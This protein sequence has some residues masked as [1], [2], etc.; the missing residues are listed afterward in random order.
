[1]EYF[2]L[3]VSAVSVGVLLYNSKYAQSPV[4]KA[5]EKTEAIDHPA[6]NTQ[7]F[8]TTKPF[9]SIKYFIGGPYDPVNGQHFEDGYNL[10]N[11]PTRDYFTPTGQ[12]V[13][14]YGFVQHGRTSRPGFP[15]YV[16]PGTPVADPAG[17]NTD[18][19]IHAVKPY[20][21]LGRHPTLMESQYSNMALKPDENNQA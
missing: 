14:T 18:S 2:V 15:A 4:A 3:G 7:P 13:R 12:R 5:N 9:K 1:M 11:I 17:D 6:G 16:L 20:K 8:V 19:A 10:Y 21:N